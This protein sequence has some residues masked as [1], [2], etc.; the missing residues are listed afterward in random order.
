MSEICFTQKMDIL[1]PTGEKKKKTQLL[2]FNYE[3]DLLNSL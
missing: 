1:S 3:T 2:P